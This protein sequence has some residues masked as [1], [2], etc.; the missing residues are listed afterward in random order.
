MEPAAKHRISHRALAFAKLI[1]AC[2][3]GRAS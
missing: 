3:A 1:A 2:F